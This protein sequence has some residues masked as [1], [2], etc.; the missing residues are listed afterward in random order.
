MLIAT[1][2]HQTAFWFATDSTYYL[3]TTGYASREELV[4]N[5]L[6]DITE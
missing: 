2:L 5:L 6:H 3:P 1:D 4:L